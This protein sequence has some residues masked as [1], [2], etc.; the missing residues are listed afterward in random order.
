MDTFL[1]PDPIFFIPRNIVCIHVFTIGF[2]MVSRLSG[3]YLGLKLKVTHLAVAGDMFSTLLHSMFLNNLYT[4]DQSSSWWVIPIFG[5]LYGIQRFIMI[6]LRLTN[7]WQALRKHLWKTMVSGWKKLHQSP[8]PPTETP[9]TAQ[10]SEEPDGL[11][12]GTNVH[13]ENFSEDAEDAAFSYPLPDLEARDVVNAGAD[14]DLGSRRY[15]EVGTPPPRISVKSSSFEDR[16]NPSPTADIVEGFR[17]LPRPRADSSASFRPRAGTT[18]ADALARPRADSSGAM[19]L[20]RRMSNSNGTAGGTMPRIIRSGP[21]TPKQGQG[22]NTSVST[23]QRMNASNGN[24]QIAKTQLAAPGEFE[25][26]IAE[27]EDLRDITRNASEATPHPNGKTNPLSHHPRRPSTASSRF[28]TTEPHPD[29]WPSYVHLHLLS[30]AHGCVARGLTIIA[31]ISSLQLLRYGPNARHYHTLAPY[32]IH[33]SAY[34]AI[35]TQT[36]ITFAAELVASA[37]GHW[38]LYATTG[39]TVWQEYRRFVGMYPEVAV[40]E[41][42]TLFHVL[43]DS[44][45]MLIK[46][47]F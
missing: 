19:A 21:L 8:S 35:V 6:T 31:F 33:D 37:L 10:R 30:E 32:F 7:L 23:G 20:S 44:T 3:N 5:V 38:W 26:E 2:K 29:T 43:L 17:S 12:A 46:L 18:G 22:S 45:F 28:S 14:S 1:F 34:T 11:E 16:K 25:P 41:A 47:E 15:S 24:P 9:N 13:L 4:V 27:E 36:C 42:L 39:I 40:F